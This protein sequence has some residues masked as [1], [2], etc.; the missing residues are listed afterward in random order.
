MTTH[1]SLDTLVALA[2]AIET[3]GE[4]GL[5]DLASVH[6]FVGA[7]SDV[8]SDQGSYE[9]FL[10]YRDRQALSLIN[11]L[12]LV[13]RICPPLGPLQQAQLRKALLQLSLS[14]KLLPT[15][16]HVPEIVEV[17]RL[18]ETPN[19]DTYR[20]S[21]EG[22]VVSLKKYRCYRMQP[23]EAREIMVAEA[24]IWSTL[25]HKNVVP[26]LGVTHDAQGPND[27]ALY[28]VTPF[29]NH[30]TIVDYLAAS[31][32]ANRCLL[33]RDVIEGLSYLHSNHV[34]HGTIKGANILVTASGRASIANVELSDIAVEEDPTWSRGPWKPSL[35][36]IAWKAPELLL[37]LQ[38]EGPMPKPTRASDVYA[39]ACVAYEIFTDKAPFWHISPQA[40]SISRVYSIT[41]AV[42]GRDERP[43]KPENGSEAYL[44]HGLTAEIWKMMEECW[45]KVPL[46]R[47]SATELSAL[48]FFTSL[49]DER[50]MAAD[51]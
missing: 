19:V 43:A 29:P 23:E 10:D 37:A 25:T 12:H 18:C 1:S 2:C 5:R 8:I 32:N 22:R 36:S 45:A 48:S 17:Q 42:L 3:V 50:P 40:R 39:L 6:N 14:S 35:G 16:L 30:G 49:V 33:L 20:G 13:L 27:Q 28:L 11:S 51:Y 38:S 31:P 26:F 4:Q 34:V 9:R 41:E 21:C 47:P 44:E 46:L 7:A 15:V 24:T